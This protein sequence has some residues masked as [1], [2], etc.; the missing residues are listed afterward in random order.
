MQALIQGVLAYCRVG[1]A[2]K[3]FSAISSEAALRQALG[4]LRKAIEDSGG[5][6]THDS[7]PTINADNV[8]L[9]QLFQ[10]IVGNAIKYRGTEPPRVHVSARK[11]VAQEWVFSV[12][13]NGL[14]IESQYFEKIFLMFQR[15]HGR[16]E[17]S[18]MGIGL[19]VCKKIV[20]RHG[21]RM[22]VEST[23]GKGSIFYISLPERGP[24]EL[25][26]SA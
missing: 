5:V 13:D 24:Y 7:L 21:G 2:G 14:G 1:T 16:G 23:P 12:S 6:V 26:Q 9:A 25:R 3:E 10:N 22:W 17:F 8:Q 19:T 15:L 4:N 11:T 18:G 20:E